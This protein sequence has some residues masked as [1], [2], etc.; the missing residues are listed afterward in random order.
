MTRSEIALG[1]ARGVVVELGFARNEEFISP[2][3]A[4]TDNSL[5]VELAD[6]LL[7]QKAARFS[8]A[9]RTDYRQAGCPV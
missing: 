9:Y 8:R 3:P 7:F 1:I 4:N 6:P 5:T 2:G